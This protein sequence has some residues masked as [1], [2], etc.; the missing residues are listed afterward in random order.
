MITRLFNALYA[1]AYLLLALTSLF[2]AGNFVLARG[3][4]EHVPPV[5]LSWARW[6]IASLLILPFAIPHLRRDWPVIRQSFPILLF[7]GT[8]GVG[9]FNTLASTIRIGPAH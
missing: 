8:V 1:N 7:L 3:V 2:W 9:A 4:H 5:A 6:S